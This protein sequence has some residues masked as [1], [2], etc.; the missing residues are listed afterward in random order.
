MNNLKNTKPY[1]LEL[2]STSVYERVKI[3][4]ILFTL[5]YSIVN[6]ND[7]SDSSLN[8]YLIIPQSKSVF[9]LTKKLK[10]DNLSVIKYDEIVSNNRKMFAPVFVS[11][12]WGSK[13]LLSSYKFDYWH[14]LHED[15]KYIALSRGRWI[16]Y[17]KM[18]KLYYKDWGS[19]GKVFSLEAIKQ[20]Y[21]PICDWKDSLIARPH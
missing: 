19:S 3:N 7:C 21:F 17:T 9:K 14:M 5:G 11:S 12:V 6:S 16:G 2:S 10:N 4:H 15:I 13:D 20:D 1:Y 18:P 8:Y